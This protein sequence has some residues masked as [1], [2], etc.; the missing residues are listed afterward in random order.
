MEDTGRGH[1]RG[2]PS[3]REPI[4]GE[5]KPTMEALLFINSDSA[6]YTRKNLSAQYILDR[7]VDMHLSRRKR[8]L[9]DAEMVVSR[10]NQSALNKLG[11]VSTGLKGQADIDLD[12]ELTPSDVTTVDERFNLWWEEWKYNSTR[13]DEAGMGIISDF[14]L[15][16]NYGQEILL[17][18]RSLTG[19]P[20][21]S[22]VCRAWARDL[23]SGNLIESEALQELDPLPPVLVFLRLTSLSVHMRYFYL[24]SSLPR[25]DRYFGK[26]SQ[27]QYCWRRRGGIH[28]SSE[29]L[30]CAGWHCSPQNWR[31]HYTLRGYDTAGWMVLTLEMQAH[32][33]GKVFTYGSSSWK[34]WASKATGGNLPARHFF[35]IGD[36]K[37]FA[38]E[39]WDLIM[40]IRM[41]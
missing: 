5:V 38:G 22:V 30:E 10:P 3:S 41:K 13:R 18:T 21:Q 25:L 17:T 26:C 1:T 15:S 4:W 6:M 11:P 24:R 37:E 36:H 32:N 27:A 23:R 34:A 31:Y 7:R 16:Y 35:N 20:F 2:E 14:L 12:K 29:R 33:R 39:D 19:V 28:A 40:G 9:S 8:M